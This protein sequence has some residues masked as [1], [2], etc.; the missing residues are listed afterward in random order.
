MFVTDTKSK[1]STSS[2]FYTGMSEEAL[3]EIMAGDLTKPELPHLIVSYLKRFL[4]LNT[5]ITEKCC[6][7][8]W[9]MSANG[10]ILS[11]FT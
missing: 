11:F 2:A 9:R 7:L 6:Y 4:V 10:L 1:L 5:S 3:N 8:L